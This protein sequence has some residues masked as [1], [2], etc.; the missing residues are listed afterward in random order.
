MGGLVLV[1]GGYV[2]FWNESTNAWSRFSPT[3]PYLPAYPD[4]F[5]MG[6]Y[7]NFAEYNPVHKVVLFG[8]GN[9]NT[10]IYK[11]DGAGQITKL[12][13]AAVGLG[14]TPARV[15]V[16]P[17]S[18]EYLVLN[19]DNSYYYSI[20]HAY[21]V[22][23]DTWKVLGTPLT[24][25]HSANSAGVIAVPISTYGVTMFLAN[26]PSRVFLY[27][28]SPS[29]GLSG[30]TRRPAGNLM[31]HAWPNPF[32]SVTKLMFA[33]FPGIEKGALKIYDL[34]GKLVRDLSPKL[35]AG[36]A[37]LDG[38]ALAQGVYLARL[39]VQGETY[40]YRLVLMR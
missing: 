4:Y 28:H 40:D 25:G 29:A 27:K 10:D 34:S 20:F 23:A 9:G 38:R 22:I 2:D 30:K 15:T 32:N 17:V 3:A 35:T 6:D 21:D 26:S 16:D 19:H 13:N 31:V 18:G 1:G 5:P 39:S 33:G 12:N 14:L 37:E 36:Q 7:Q 11:L 24:S 8:G